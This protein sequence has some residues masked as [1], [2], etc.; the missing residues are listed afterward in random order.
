[1][2]G[3]EKSTGQMSCGR[4]YRRDLISNEVVELE[5]PVLLPAP[6]LHSGGCSR[7]T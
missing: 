6:A 5:Y 2:V 1:M 4:S 3:S 7:E